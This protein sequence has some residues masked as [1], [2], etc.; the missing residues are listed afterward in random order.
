MYILP[1]PKEMIMGKEQFIIKY[2]SVIVIDKNCDTIVNSYA[3]ILKRD[4]L[5]NIGFALSVTKGEQRKN[6][7]YLGIDPHLKGEEY[8]LRVDKDY[9][10][11]LGASNISILYGVQSLRQIISQKRAVLPCLTIKDYP[12]MKNRGFYHDVTR[13][14]IPTLSYLKEF[15]D[16]LSYYKINQL[17]LYIE[18]SF[19]FE[20]FSEVWRDDT[21]LTPEEI[22]EL[23][24][25]CSNLGIELVPSLSSFGHLYKLLNTKT[26]GHLC[27]LPDWEEEGFSFLGRMQHHTLDIS[28]DESFELVKKM[29]KDFMPLFR[30]KHFNICADETFDLGKGRSKK[31]AD[32]IGVKKMYVGFVKKLCKFIVSEGSTPM[33]WGDIISGFPQAI[34]ELPKETI[35]LNW[36][37]APDQKEDGIKALYEVGATQYLCPGVAGWNQFINLIEDSYK[38]IKLMCEYGYKYEAVGILNTDW[39][40][41][42]H[43]NH[44]ELSTIGMIY[45]AAFSWNKKIPPFEDINRQISLLEFKDPGE[46]FVSM[47]AKISTLSLYD[48]HSVVQF[49]ERKQSG[50]AK[51]DYEEY[52]DK[53]RVSDVSKVNNNLENLIEKLYNYSYIDSPRVAKN[54]IK[55]Y[56]IAADGIYLFN[57]IGSIIDQRIFNKDHGL[58]KKE[59]TKLAS[60]LEKW[61][62]HYKEIWRSV[63][64][65]SEL[66]LIQDVIL[67]YGD[68]LRDL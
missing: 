20:D 51:E 64:K 3:G 15:A 28:N 34:Q 10:S 41:F 49:K 33:F 38:N 26:Y 11:I 62:Y 22:M 54:L 45:G 40:D 18:H 23:D 30:S 4:I 1:G 66:H 21:P 68:Y 44:P 47:V 65:E 60:K 19:L 5:Q 53:L 48:W 25:Y 67:W 36:G 37:Y 2:H 35:C 31:L 24:D 9:I 14:R 16:K 57:V 55:P 29:I 43:I 46:Q 7:I 6:S 13:G 17:Q 59:Y 50:K 8:T 42:G 63:S 39:G 56:L 27:E 58:V 52:F 12:D 61:F 32:Q